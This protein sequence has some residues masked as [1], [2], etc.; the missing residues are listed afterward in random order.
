MR[1][2]IEVRVR[3]SRDRWDGADGTALPA[4]RARMAAALIMNIEVLTMILGYICFELL[5]PRRVEALV[6]LRKSRSAAKVGKG[7]HESGESI[8]LDKSSDKL[9]FDLIRTPAVGSPK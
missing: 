5:I 2:L 8:L 3:W 4:W 1:I 6:R 9:C 7:L